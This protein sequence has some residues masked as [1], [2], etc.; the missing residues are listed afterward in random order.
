MR[1]SREM[2]EIRRLVR[3][4]VEPDKLARLVEVLDE[5]H[6]YLLYRA[7]SRLKEALSSQTEA[8]FRFEAG[9]ISIVRT[10][11]RA[12]FEAWITPEL[13][14]IEG[15]VDRALAEANLA[16]DQIDRIFLTGGSSLVPAVRDIFHRR[17]DSQRIETGSEL[18][19]IASGLALMGRER[20]LGRWCRRA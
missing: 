13:T 3:D 1:A 12:E 14:L 18:E 17:F 9:D 8:E 10:V 5:N 16:P 15:A 2:R 6:G 11:A 7:V 20:D 4:A 19:S